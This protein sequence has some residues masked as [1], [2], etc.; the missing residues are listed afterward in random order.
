MRCPVLFAVLVAFPATPSSRAA[1][2]LDFKRDVQ[3]IFEQRCYECH[4]EK[5]QKSGLRMDRKAAVFRGGDSGKPAIIGGKSSQSP[6]LQR[7]T[8]KDPDEVMPPKGEPLSEAQV[9]SIRQWIDQYLA[10][11]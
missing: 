3:P 5:K 11:Y 10:L 8:S 7:L 4:G 1:A 2:K 6:L 9:D